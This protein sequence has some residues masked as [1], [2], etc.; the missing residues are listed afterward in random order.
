MQLDN[1]LA[2][3][4]GKGVAVFR[5]RYYHGWVR[6]AI[7]I[8]HDEG[9]HGLYKGL[10]P[11]LIREAI[12]S[13]IRLG[14]YEPLKVALGATDPAHTPLWKKITAG[15]TSD[16]QHHQYRGQPAAPPSGEIQRIAVKVQKKTR[17]SMLVSKI[18]VP[19]KA[20]MEGSGILAL[21][22]SEEPETRTPLPALEINRAGRDTHRDAGNARVGERA[23]ILTA[24]QIP[25]YDHTKHTILNRGWMR[26]GAT[27]HITAS[28]IAGFATA[29]STSPVDVIKT[30]VMNQQ[31]KG[32]GSSR[33]LVYGNAL[34]CLVKTIRSEGIVGLYKGFFPNWM[35]IGP[36]TIITFFIF[37]QLRS[38]IGMQPV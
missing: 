16:R 4:R 28:M 26:E 24:M 17:V 34:D 31:V 22:G 37:E 38:A 6:G 27:L 23:A 20:P 2:E 12:Y 29:F 5:E 35:R 14:A 18:P 7:Q 10:L 32:S 3:Q 30:R 15:A 36:H 1:E 19:V 13:G 8:V 11:S 21:V 33:G 9:I 25:A